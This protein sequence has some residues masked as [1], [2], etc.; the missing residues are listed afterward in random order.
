ML[1]LEASRHPAA[2]EDE[3]DNMSLDSDMDNSED[4]EDRR[5]EAQR[6]KEK[7][8]RKEEER[9][10]KEKRKRKERELEEEALDPMD[11]AAYSDIAR[12]TWSAGQ[13]VLG[14]LIF[15]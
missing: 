8:A 9:R 7:A 13:T 5:L 14:F 10:L 11:P 12:G 3:E 2:G 1:A 6:K 15:I 4:E